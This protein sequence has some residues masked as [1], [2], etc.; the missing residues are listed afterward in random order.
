MAHM[1]WILRFGDVQG[2]SSQLQ[3]TLYGT[4]FAVQSS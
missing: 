4:H 3:S 1:R 2:E